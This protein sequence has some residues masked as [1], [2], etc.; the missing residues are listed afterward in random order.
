MP[1]YG[2]RITRDFN[3]KKCQFNSFIFTKLIETVPFVEQ[4]GKNRNSTL[5]TN[6]CNKER[7]IL[8]MILVVEY[9]GDRSRAIPQGFSLY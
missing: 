6:K 5:E 7:Y 4:R 9:M 1:A 8:N 2:H 3:L